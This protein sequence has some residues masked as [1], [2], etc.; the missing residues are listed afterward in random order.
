MSND[1]SSAT[2]HGV[3]PEQIA[4]YAEKDARSWEAA[5]KSM[6][7]SLRATPEQVQELAD[8]CR[9]L[10]QP[11]TTGEHIHHK[12]ADDL[13]QDFISPRDVPPPTTPEHLM[14]VDYAGIEQRLLAGGSL[15]DAQAELLYEMAT[16][17]GPKRSRMLT[18]TEIIMALL[19]VGAIVAAFIFVVFAIKIW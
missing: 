18:P 19:I 8:S 9:A 10:F 6:A 12:L 2:W 14:N 4:E 7:E 15:T 13:Y 17:R 1:K 11:E 3:T 5:Q 16:H